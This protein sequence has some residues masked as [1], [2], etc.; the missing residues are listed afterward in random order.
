MSKLQYYQ[1]RLNRSNHMDTDKQMWLGNMFLHSH[2]AVY[3]LSVLL[4][5]HNDNYYMNQECLYNAK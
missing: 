1:Y 5:K 3:N 2:M 4:L